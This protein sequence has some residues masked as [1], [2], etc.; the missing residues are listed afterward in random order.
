MITKYTI[1]GERCSGTNYIYNIMQLNFN[2]IFTNEYGH[3]HFFGFDKYK[4]SDDTLFIGI[5]REP[6]SWANSFYR[7]KHHL[8]GEITKSVDKFLNTEVRSYS[9][10]ASFKTFISR[11]LGSNI[12][13]STDKEIIADRNA[14]TGEPFKNVMELRHYKLKYLIE[15]MPMRVNNY[16]LIRYEDL[17]DNFEETIESIRNKFSLKIKNNIDYPV[18]T[19]QYK[20]TNRTYKL[21]DKIIMNR[22]LIESHL[23]FNIQCE[24]QLNYL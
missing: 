5:V 2:L 8:R 13:N 12:P 24:K 6:F 20:K 21:I 4:D 1:F 11:E 17:R 15:E 19:T 3:K 18:N 9:S 14:F 10:P 16:I 23:D 7:D 22:E